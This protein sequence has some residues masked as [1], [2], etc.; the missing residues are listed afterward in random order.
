MLLKIYGIVT[1]LNLICGLKVSHDL[2]K[3]KE[4]LKEVK[5]SISGRMLCK[6]YNKLKVI[7]TSF[8]PIINVWKCIV[9]SLYFIFNVFNNEES[10][11]AFIKILQN[12]D[13]ENN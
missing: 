2:F 8:I 6:N 12:M 1:V 11:K 5:S 7:L 3:D 9:N 4:F 13:K 10:K